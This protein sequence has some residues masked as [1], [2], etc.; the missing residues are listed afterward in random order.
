MS[1]RTAPRKSAPSRPSLGL[2][3]LAL[4]FGACRDRPASGAAGAPVTAPASAPAAVT[5]SP[6][7]TPPTGALPAPAATRWADLEASEQACADCHPDHADAWFATK[8]GRSLLKIDGVAHAALRVPGSVTHPLTGLTYTQHNGKFTERAAP[9]V[10]LARDAKYVIGSGHHAQSFL[11]AADDQ[12]YQLPLTWFTE[13]RRWDLSPGYEAMV[14]HPGSFREV[15]IDCLNCHTDPVPL[16]AGTRNRFE[17]LPEGPI[18]CSRCHGDGRAHAEARLNGQDAPVVVPTRLSPERAADTCAVCHFGGAVRVLRPGRQ[19]ADFLPGDVLSDV[20][21]IFVRQQAGEGFGT[22]DHFS[23]LGMSPCAQKTPH[24]TC[25]TCHPPHVT[26]PRGPDDRSASCRVCHG[27]GG[28]AEAHPCTGPGGKDCAGC[29]MDTGPSRNIPHVSA[30]DHFIRTRPAPAPPRNND[31]P[32]VWVARP[33]TDPADPDHQILLGRAYVAAWRS[34]GQPKDAER[35][36]RFLSRGVAALPDR[37]D[38]WLELATLRRLRGDG[39]GERLAAEKAVSLDPNGRRTATIVGAAR[40]AA[41]DAEGALVALDRAAAVSARAETE[42]LRARALQLLGRMGDAVSAART[43]TALQPSYAEAWLALGILADAE[44]RLEDAASALETAVR[45][46]PRNVRAWLKL[47]A[48][49]N[50]LGRA[51]NALEAFEKAETLVGSDATARQLVTFGK[52]EAQVELGRTSEALPTLEVLLRDGLR[53]PGMP[54]AMGRAYVATGN[55]AEALDALEAAVRI[56]PD[57]ATA[58]EAL[59]VARQEMNMPLPAAE[60]RNRAATLRARK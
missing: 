17:A 9:G 48:V 52:A 40:L 30:V 1:T 38:G 57:D 58:W 44:R 28:R 6:P 24:M 5:A 2:V 36:E 23:R 32:L 37:L 46:Q 26:D 49:R 47:G 21:A 50:R 42:T 60:A 34:D 45:W 10:E 35:A 14:D 16:R 59:A 53:V 27:A 15:T 33:E 56:D 54:R 18:G 29:H 4:W 13:Q 7:G 3:V 22:T 39:P 8:M 51:T 19:W 20:A 55:F 11:W 41:G 25:A 12:L 31:S 43:A